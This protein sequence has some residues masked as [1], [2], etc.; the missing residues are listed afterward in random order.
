MQLSGLNNKFSGHGTRYSAVKIK[1]T[2]YKSV[3]LDFI[4]NLYVGGSI[5]KEFKN[6]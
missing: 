3:I 6:F 4:S 2:T 1:A 5:S